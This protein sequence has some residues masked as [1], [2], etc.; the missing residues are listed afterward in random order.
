[1]DIGAPAPFHFIPGGLQAP[2]PSQQQQSPPQQQQEQQQQ[3]AIRRK[4]SPQGPP[5]G[6]YGG[7]QAPPAF[8]GQIRPNSIHTIN[9]GNPQE[10]ATGG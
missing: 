3:Q 8:Q 7:G 2:P 10:L 1:M 9:S 4:P 6:S 5:G